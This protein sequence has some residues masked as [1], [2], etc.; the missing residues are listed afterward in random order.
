MAR[1]FSELE[2]KMSP[3]ARARS[4]A[5]AQRILKEMALDELREALS[6][7]QQQLAETMGMAQ[8]SVSKIVRGRDM[9]LSTLDKFI[10]AMGGELEVRVVFPHG[11]VKL[12]LAQFREAAG[13]ERKAG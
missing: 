12:S 8:A 5:E 4:H 6:L 7:T 9:Y 2:A 1:K 10:H 13:A 3:E 11:E